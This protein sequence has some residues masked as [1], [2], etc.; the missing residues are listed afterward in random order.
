MTDQEVNRLLRRVEMLEAELREVRAERDRAR[1]LVQ[2]AAQALK[3]IQS[4]IAVVSTWRETERERERR[5]S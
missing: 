1:S 2:T 4:T 5:E 3:H